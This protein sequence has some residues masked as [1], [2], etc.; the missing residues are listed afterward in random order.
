MPYIVFVFIW[1]ILLSKTIYSSN[2]AVRHTHTHT[3]KGFHPFFRL[4]N[5][6]LYLYITAFLNLF[7]HWWTLF[8]WLVFIPYLLWIMLQC[9]WSQSYLFEITILYPLDIQPEL[10]LLDYIYRLSFNFLRN[11]HTAFCTG[12]PDLHFHKSCTR[13]PFFPYHHHHSLSFVFYININK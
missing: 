5:I 8:V 6:L 2:H 10:G 3:H 7:I 4:N 13:V 12:C 11:F 1:H 9:R